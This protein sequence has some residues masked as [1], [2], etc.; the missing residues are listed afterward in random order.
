MVIKLAEKKGA[1]QLLKS[2][3]GVVWKAAKA[4]LMVAGGA[5]IIKHFSKEKTE[6]EEV[7]LSDAAKSVDSST[8]IA[9]GIKMPLASEFGSVS[10][11]SDYDAYDA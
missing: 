5:S 10:D 9:S 4:A 7:K 1:F 6:S 8:K 11:D 3:V 2:G